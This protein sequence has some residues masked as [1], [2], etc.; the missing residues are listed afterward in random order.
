MQFPVRHTRE[1]TW[2][3]RQPS[4]QEIAEALAGAIN[5]A[6]IPDDKIHRRIQQPFHII[7]K[8]EPVIED[9]GW[10]PRPDRIGIEPAASAPGQ[11]TGRQALNER[12]GG[13]QGSDHGLK[14]ISDTH[15]PRHVRLGAEIQID[16]YSGGSEHHIQTMSAD[17][18]HIAA[19]DRVALLGHPRYIVAPPFGLKADTKKTDAQFLADAPKQPQ[20]IAHLGAGLMH[21]N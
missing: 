3:R 16:L 5:I 14:A 7:F 9:H 17:L 4:G 2:Q 20:M 13:E 21:A 10:N 12:A 6:P 8:T 19:H 11:Q 18:G 1:L 15:L